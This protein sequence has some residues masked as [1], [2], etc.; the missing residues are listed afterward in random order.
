M[1]MY[2][3]LDPFEKS[4]QILYYTCTCTYS[5]AM[6]TGNSILLTKYAC[7]SAPIYMYFTR[8]FLDTFG[9]VCNLS[10]WKFVMEILFL[11]RV[12]H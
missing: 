10:Y 7:T 4:E 8:V 2:I 6:H 11:G 5:S 9:N 1:H 12:L 3:V